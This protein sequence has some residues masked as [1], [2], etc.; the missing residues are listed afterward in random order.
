MRF[1]R[2]VRTLRK[3]GRVT[4]PDDDPAARGFGAGALKTNNKIFAMISSKGEFVV[5]LSRARVD[6]LVAAGIGDR[7]DGG[8]GRPLKEWLVVRETAHRQWLRLA[9]EAMLY[10]DSG[11]GE[12]GSPGLPSR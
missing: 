5:K 6:A 11:R 12:K 4:A 10:A 3:D 8:R 9:R 7:F 1:N 2:I